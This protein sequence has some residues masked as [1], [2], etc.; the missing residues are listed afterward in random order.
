M[1]PIDIVLVRH[2]EAEINLAKALSRAGDNSLFTPEFRNRHSSSFRLTKHGQR[3]SEMAGDW[4][5]NSML[6]RLRAFDCYL[7]SPYKRAMET[8]ATL[9]LPG[10]LWLPDYRLRERDWGYLDVCPDNEAR[11]LYASALH[12]WSIEPFFS[13]PP[14]GESFAQLCH[15][16][17]QII[18]ILSRDWSGKR[19]IIVC[20]SDVMMA[21]RFILERIPIDR[22]K[23]LI[24]SGK[25]EDRVYNCQII[26]YSRRHPDGHGTSYDAVWV[27]MIRP[28]SRPATTTPWRK[29]E[30]EHLYTN[31]EL[32]EM[33]SSTPRLIFP[34]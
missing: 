27:Q 15:R 14:Q 5:E 1:L 29:I 32:L 10:A 22:F 12:E 20:H 31:K 6:S 9:K 13:K 26:H 18:A 17:E 3:Q 8:A 11:A 21:F 24:L 19:V 28:T 2:G 25:K 30:Q 16:V 23:E 7:T 33:V 4:I 34:G